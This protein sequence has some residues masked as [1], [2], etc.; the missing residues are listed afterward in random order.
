MCLRLDREEAT[1]A[2]GG[3]P[4]PLYLTSQGVEELGEHGPL[5][6][7]FAHV[8]WRDFTLQL[9]AGST[10]VAYTDGF[11][12]ARNEAGVR[13]GLPRLRDT[14]ADL[15]ARPT[16]AGVSPAAEAIA[17]L[18]SELDEFQAGAHTDDTAAIALH[19]CASVEVCGSIERTASAV[20]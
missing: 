18:S 5:L 3:H 11:T 15:G 6:G 2:V 17:G 10:L 20:M 19:R 16:A 14:L 4:P 1:L 7:A 8:S 9:Q 13:F 12:D